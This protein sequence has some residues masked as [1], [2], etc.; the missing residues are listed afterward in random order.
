MPWPLQAGRENTDSYE[1]PPPGA[2]FPGAL[3]RTRHRQL[4]G[5]LRPRCG[6]PVQYLVLGHVN[7]GDVALLAHQL[8]Q[9]VAVPPAPTAQV[10]YPAAL[11]A[12]RHHQATAIVP[13]GEGRPTVSICVFLLSIEKINKLCYNSPVT[14]Q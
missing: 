14:W 4:T 9:H 5:A 2:H 11:Q 10:Q 8:T 3:L 7:A 12:L 1:V 13:E 6:A